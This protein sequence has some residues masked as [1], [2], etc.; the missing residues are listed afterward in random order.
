LLDPRA[1][2]TYFPGAAEG[3]VGFSSAGVALAAAPTVGFYGC[4]GSLIVADF[5]PSQVATA[6]IAA[7]QHTTAST[8]L[9]LVST[10]ANGITVGDSI[11]RADTGATVTG[12]LRIDDTPS[13]QTFGQSKTVA[14]WDPT[15]PPVGR[16]VSLTTSA[17]MSSVAL[18]IRGYDAY[19]YPVTQTVTLPSSATTVN[20]TK[21]FKWIA[22]V[23]ASATDAGNNVSVGTAD[24]WGLPLRSDRFFYVNGSCWNNI[25]LLTAQFTAAVLTDPSTA[26]TGD[27]RG[28]LAAVTTT[29]DGT[30]RLQILQRLAPGNV[31]TVTGLFGIA[32]T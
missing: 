20:T 2:Y 3:P 24:I 29:S 14:V 32:Q 15:K 31:G 6:N 7:L 12:L 26:S 18:T 11:V 9:T 19:G 17:S 22:S 21:T 4:G 28:T 5:A 8:A 23:T 27:V 1:A 30:K 25:A 16:A 13:F 10:T